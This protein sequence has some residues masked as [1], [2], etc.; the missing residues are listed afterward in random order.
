MKSQ[1]VLRIVTFETH[2]FP[3]ERTTG[4]LRQFNRRVFDLT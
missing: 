4:V 2:P 3:R 1:R